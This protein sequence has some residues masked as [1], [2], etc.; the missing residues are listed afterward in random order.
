MTKKVVV[1]VRI[2]EDVVHSFDKKIKEQFGSTRG[3]KPEVIEDLLKTYIED[4]HNQAILEE[5]TKQVE[6]LQHQLHDTQQDYKQM[7][8]ELEN[9]KNNYN[10]IHH[11]VE[12]KEEKLEEQQQRYEKRIAELEEKLEQQQQR[13]EEKLDN[14][15]KQIT[16]WSNKYTHQVEVHQKL[17]GEHNQ[18]QKKQEKYANVFGAITH[19]A[20]WDRLLGNY[21]EEI[22]ELQPAQTDQE[23]NFTQQDE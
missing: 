11:Q 3:H 21:P 9:W 15:D 20:W 13:Y 6:T 12:K 1:S 19:M 18:L 17:E 14:K 4:D 22:K 2:N 16:T 7:Q 23:K 10:D 8:E 5:T